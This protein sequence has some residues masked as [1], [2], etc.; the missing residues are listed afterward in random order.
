V[1]RPDLPDGDDPPVDPL[2]PEV[3]LE[4]FAPPL[5]ELAE[6]LRAVVRSAVP[7]AVERV[8]PG[9]RVIGYDVPSAKRPRFFCWVFPERK[10]VH[11]GF[12]NGVLMRDP[13]G[14]LDGAGITKLARWF[15]FEPGDTVDPRLLEPFVHEAADVALLPPAAREAVRS[16]R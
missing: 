1:S 6:Q 3:F 4:A 10:H 9:W 7:D 2:P 12:V 14:L 16:S 5:R 13:D 8:R 15:T 11:L